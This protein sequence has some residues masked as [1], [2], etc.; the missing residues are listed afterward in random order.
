MDHAQVRKHHLDEGQRA[1]DVVTLLVNR[2]PGPGTRMDHEDQA[3]QTGA[4]P[5]AA[6]QHRPVEQLLV[7]SARCGFHRVR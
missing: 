2:E 7:G 6:N 1:G 5:E 3:Q 4:M